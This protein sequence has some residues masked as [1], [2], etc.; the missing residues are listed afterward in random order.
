[1]HYQE[2]DG[3]SLH[4]DDID[5]RWT[6]FFWIGAS[7]RAFVGVSAGFNVAEFADF[8]LGWFG[9][10]IADDDDRYARY[11]GEKI[12]HWRRR[13]SSEK[14]S[15]RRDAIQ[16]ICA[17]AKKNPGLIDELI[18]ALDHPDED[19]AYKAVE[20]LGEIPQAQDTSIPI[21]IKLLGDERLPI[22][23]EA[24]RSLGNLGPAG[25]DAVPILQKA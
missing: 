17:I 25:K 6:D 23:W 9:I 19:V 12:S 7:A 21:L 3:S 18:E 15:E 22:A 4:G 14:E 24:V 10:D 11:G 5:S 8:L 16:A 20:A 1:M 2:R 13:L